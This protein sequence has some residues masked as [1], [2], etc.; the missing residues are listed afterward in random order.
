MFPYVGKQQQQQYV[1]STTQQL[2]S[3]PTIRGSLGNGWSV[4]NQ[5][6]VM[7]NVS[8]SSDLSKETKN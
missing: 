5:K 3:L 7:L 6:R 4:E 2:S 1:H 8:I